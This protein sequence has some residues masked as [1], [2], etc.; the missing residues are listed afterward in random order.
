MLPVVG[1]VTAVTGDRMTVA[2]FLSGAE[3]PI[4][5]AYD[6]VGRI[7]EPE[8]NPLPAEPAPPKPAPADPNKVSVDINA[9]V[10]PAAGK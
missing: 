5:W 1:I 2:P 9:P 8:A 7:T 6:P 10:V 3:F 4:A